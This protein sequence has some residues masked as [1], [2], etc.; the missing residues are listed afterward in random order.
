MCEL[1]CEFRFKFKFEFV[2]FEFGSAPTFETPGRTNL[3]F[4]FELMCELGFKFKFKFVKFVKFEFRFKFEFGFVCIGQRRRTRIRSC[5][6][7]LIHR[8]QNQR[9]RANLPCNGQL[10]RPDC[11]SFGA[12]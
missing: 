3:K 11:S 10:S 9:C 2:K 4:M 8:Q 12:T 7:C 1:M 6:G 5:A